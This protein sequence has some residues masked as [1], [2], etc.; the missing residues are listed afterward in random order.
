MKKK[1]STLFI[2]LFI[3]M[4]F[5]SWRA[6]AATLPPMAN[7]SGQSG[8][9][10][11]VISAILG[12][13]LDDDSAPGGPGVEPDPGPWN[14]D[15]Q[16]IAIGTVP[17]S[18]NRDAG[19]LPGSMDVSNGAAIYSMPLTLPPGVEDV[20]PILKLNYSG[21]NSSGVAGLGWSI[22][23]LSKIDRCGR[24][25][26]THG[27]TDVAR[28]LPRDRLCLDGAPLILANG[29]NN[30]DSAYWSHTAQ[31]RTEVDGF[32]RIQAVVINGRVS[33][34]V[35]TK[36]GLVLTYGDRDDAY[37]TGQGRSDGLAHRWWL[38]SSTDRS[39]NRI[40]YTYVTNA[41]T[42]ESQVSNVR[43]G[44]NPAAGKPMLVKAEFAYEAKPD[45]RSGYVSGSHFDERLRLKSI[46]T[47]TDTQTDGSGGKVVLRYNL[48]YTLSA[49]SGRSLLDSVQACDAAGAC[50]PA[51][52]FKWGKKNPAAT[53][54]F[55][56]LGG[57]RQGPNLTS[58]AKEVQNYARR[59][60]DM[61]AIGDFNGDGK[62][63]LLERYRNSDNGY[64]QRLFLSNA[65]G[66]GW[67][68]SRPM[69]GISGHVMEIADF[70]GDGKIDLLVA[71]QAAGS[72]S[73]GNWR[74][75]HSRLRTG[76]GFSCSSNLNLP[77]DASSSGALDPARVI[78]DIDGDGRDELFLSSSADANL[79]KRYKCSL[80]GGV[81]NCISVLRTS[82]DIMMEE[83]GL[84]PPSPYGRR[85]RHPYADMDGDGRPDTVTLSSCQAYKAPGQYLP[86]WDCPIEGIDVFTPHASGQRF[87]TG[88]AYLPDRKSIML[89]PARSGTFAGDF[90][91]DGLS[92][93]VFG[94]ASLQV[95][96]MLNNATVVA[97]HPMV[98]YFMGNNIP[99]TGNSDCRALPLSGGGFDHDVVTVGDFDGDGVVDVLRPR[100]DTWKTANITAYQLCHIGPDAAWHRCE[101]W[102]G[103]TFYGVSGYEKYSPKKYSI[104]YDP[105]PYSQFSGDFDGD[106]KTDIVSHHGNGNWEISSA[107]D[108]AMPGE[109]IDKLIS[110]SNGLGF[111]EKVE[112]GSINDADVYQDVALDIN[113]RPLTTSYPLTRAPNRRQ[114]VKMIKRS[115]GQG[116]WLASQ[117]RYAG[118][119]NDSS[120]RGNMGFARQ[121]VTDM[122]SGHVTTSWYR[123]DFP[124][125]GMLSASQTTRYRQAAPVSA[126]NLLSET[127]NAVKVKQINLASGRY[128]YFPY[129][130]STSV[131][132][133]DLDGSELG[134]VST[135]YD[136]D[137]YG[138]LILADSLASVTGGSSHSSRV[139]NVYDSSETTWR[140]SDLKSVK[141]SRTNAAGTIDRQVRYEY[142]A[143]GRLSKEVRQ[144][145]DVRLKL[146]VSYDRSRNPFGLINK[147][148]QEWQDPLD[149]SAK[150]RVISD[151]E[152][153]GDG[154]FPSWKK[155]ALGQVEMFLTHDAGSGAWTKR[156]DINQLVHLQAVDGLGR[157]RG[158]TGPDGQETRTD[159]KQCDYRCPANA[160]S[161]GIVDYFKQG[162]R[163]R[164]PVLAYRDNAGRTLRTQSWGFDGRTVEVDTRYDASGRVYEQDHPHVS[165]TAAALANRFSYDNLNRITRTE[166]LGETGNTQVAT[167]E[168]QGLT[169]VLVNAKGQRKTDLRDVQGSL[170][171]STDA[172]GGVT[173]F[174]YDAY[175]N[176]IG[177]VDPM[178]NVIR[179]DY[180]VLGRKTDLYDPDLGHIKYDVDAVGQVRR[181]VSPIQRAAGTSTTSEYDALG[182]MIARDEPD[183]RGR[184]LFDVAVGQ[185]NCFT[186]KSCG[187]LVEAYTVGLDGR[188]DYRRLQGFD[189]LG[190][191]VLTTTHL[192]VVYTAKTEYDAW[193][194]PFRVAYQRGN[195][196]VKAYEQR[197]NARGYL[198][199][200]SRGELL[201]WQAM[202]QDAANRV[203]VAKLGNGLTAGHTFNP[204][205]GRL[206]HGALDKAGV[207]Q[208]LESYNYD[209]LGNVKQRVQFWPGTGFAEDFD[210]DGLNRLK[211]A[212]VSGQAMQVFNYDAIGNL[213]DKTG[214]GAYTYPR[215]GAGSKW[216][217]AVKNIA[218]IGDFNYDE[219]GNLLNGAGRTITWSSFDMPK[220]L[221]KGTEKSTFV[222]GPDYQRVRQWRSD[223]ANIYYAGGME[224]E[225]K[226][227]VATVKTYWPMGLG[228]ETE[229]AGGDAMLRWT[230]M[231]RLGSVVAISDAN[232]ALQERLA[233]DSWG[234]RRSLPG[235]ATPDNLDGVTDNRGFTGHEM[236]DKLDLV[237]MNGRIYDPLTARFLSA[238]PLIQDAQHSQSYN[239]YTYVWNNPTN[240]TDPTGFMGQGESSWQQVTPDTNNCKEV[241][242]KCP[243]AG[244]AEPDAN[245]R[246]NSNEHSGDKGQNTPQVR[247]SANNGGG[248]AAER[249]VERHRSDMEAGNGAVYEPLQ[250]VAV[251]VTGAATFGSGAGWL[252]TT[253]TG[254]AFLT[255]FGFGAEVQ[256]MA[257][258]VPS[259]GRG[260][261]GAEAKAAT[262]EVSYSMQ[263]LD[264]KF[265]HASDFGLLTTKKN[266]ET[267]G[268]FQSA[269][270]AHAND[271]ATIGHGTYG[272][273]NGSRVLFN[274]NT[275]N[276]MVV[277]KA[278]QFVTGFKLA[279]GTPQYQNY[280]ANGILR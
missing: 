59:A 64:Q 18:G 39:G 260:I 245:K 67:T 50:V 176:L 177:T 90:N 277:D 138:N 171:V 242:G 25:F 244:T 268:Q 30:N 35:E 236:L 61:V 248:G 9:A 95:A 145:H 63:D 196:G 220:A 225:V 165:G 84:T 216:P 88:G 184:W 247:G 72:Y 149:N 107:A 105:A 56:S 51:S 211:T 237:H 34:R 185:N 133:R 197:Y 212:T 141:E 2:L 173:T 189:S 275:N 203:T 221:V 121:E 54:G 65:D 179:V 57:M 188:K 147:I 92:D 267:L 178:A 79:G 7:A 194:R 117:F 161:V 241:A 111:V 80:T 33:F 180:D 166:T 94:M 21:T 131:A 101:N 164:L 249:F 22:G 106:G 230:H 222:Y 205:T 89:E 255:L 191:L 152:Y 44:G 158:V 17:F 151:I 169:T 207:P 226:N 77:A 128:T 140:L 85:V 110:V 93:M 127:V 26:A 182:R 1:I 13:L 170:A 142:D 278:G 58:I 269:L 15:T 279:P 53:A 229:V 113:G 270:K 276:A 201:L 154:R 123:Q 73:T 156:S 66:N 181:Q 144:E 199:K 38:S 135:T 118:N 148:T 175:G 257:D 130:F 4:F 153:N 43:W 219:N 162:V 232:G 109:A 6:G 137:N 102:D 103:P 16:P 204:S 8:V 60:Q 274:A 70:D 190:R 134:S 233:Y 202:Q 47:Q 254:R 29:D 253:A 143:V 114:L 136:Y 24:S 108:Q 250:P 209:A 42:G 217:H 235:D 69:T 23:G 40:E 62:S 12:L 10:P 224:V 187:Q 280:L 206:S 86:L 27:A 159:E 259:A 246:S 214:L 36:A 210:Y 271:P 48:A 273:V 218:G 104:Y 37:L 11:G 97:T 240:L 167:T 174:S 119:V 3:S 264:K 20:T 52:Q 19:T 251:A 262:A 132:R 83:P 99:G 195:E 5:L 82:E 139:V 234:K 238:D 45:A 74:L 122:Q 146:T 46:T 192:D 272:F 186:A 261:A 157:K 76:E 91:S 87:S 125:N 256:G 200:V 183:L 55:V 266:P 223:D 252:A 208:L 98:C 116:G 265:K 263:Q 243:L 120:G 115:N 213:V 31:Y 172:M 150:S 75:C 231:D 228:M 160:V 112:Y 41:A 168:Y 163:S 71:D 124:F 239:R 129:V 78:L 96:P 227:G 198:E 49:T 14:P 155:N 193:D 215:Q 81:A 100:H 28:F 32:S 68:I 126:D 258:G